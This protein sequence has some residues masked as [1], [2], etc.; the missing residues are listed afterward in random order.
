M[1]LY[2]Q[3]AWPLHKNRLG[4][5]IGQRAATM[6]VERVAWQKTD[7]KSL[8]GEETRDTIGYK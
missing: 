1:G 4:G 7:R 3:P 6:S 8:T 2:S 5:P